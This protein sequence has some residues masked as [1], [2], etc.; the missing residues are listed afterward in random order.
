MI[1]MK[2]KETHQEKEE[3]DDLTK[4]I[5]KAKNELHKKLAQNGNKLNGDDVLIIS[6]KLD[7]LLDEYIEKN[8]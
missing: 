6:Q 4:E 7:K 1:K 2:E 8:K 5:K 3:N